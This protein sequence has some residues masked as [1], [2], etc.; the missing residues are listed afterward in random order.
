MMGDENLPHDFE[1]YLS[2][3]LDKE[4]EEAQDSLTELFSSGMA[5]K[6][7]DTEPGPKNLVLAYTTAGIGDFV[8]DIGGI[9][10]IFD[11]QGGQAIAQW[12]KR[13]A[14][15]AILGTQPDIPEGDERFFS[16]DYYMTGI[17]R[18][19][20]RSSLMVAPFIFAGGAGAAALH[21]GAK[22][23][24]IEAAKAGSVLG[25]GLGSGLLAMGATYNEVL[26]E[27]GDHDDAFGKSLK[28]MVASGVIN[29]GTTAMLPKILGDPGEAKKFLHNMFTKSAAVF[30]QAGGEGVDEMGQ[31]VIKGKPA[32][33]NVVD[34]MVLGLGSEVSNVAAFSAA[35]NLAAGKFWKRELDAV[36]PEL[37]NTVLDHVI[38][39]EA[40]DAA[41]PGK[42]ARFQSVTDGEILASG[43][44]PKGVGARLIDI[45]KTEVE[46]LVAQ[47][48]END[49][50]IISK[51][52]AMTGVME[53]MA[54]AGQKPQELT[55]P[56]MEPTERAVSL[57]SLDTITEELDTLHR[58]QKEGKDV[59][60]NLQVVMEKREQA[61]GAL[62]T[63]NENSVKALELDISQSPKS[64]L[65]TMAQE[66]SIRIAEAQKE[67]DLTSPVDKQKHSIASE[68]L[69]IEKSVG[70]KVLG[71]DAQL[72]VEEARID[73]Q[74]TEAV[75]A[76]LAPKY[77]KAGGVLEIGN[78]K[79]I[80]PPTGDDNA[81]IDQRNADFY[82][83][84]N[85][86]TK[87]Q[88]NNPDR[89]QVDPIPTDEKFD[90]REVL[91]DFTDEMDITL[92]QNLK[93]GRGK[94]GHMVTG[95]LH[96]S[97]RPGDMDAVSHETGHWI[98]AVY[99]ITSK[100]DENHEAELRGL[101]P[102]MDEAAE[103][104]TN[105]QVLEEG[106]SEFVRGVMVNPAE[107]LE[108]APLTADLYAETLPDGAQQKILD[109]GDTLR[110]MASKGG[111]DAIR[112]H[113]VSEKPRSLRDRLFKDIYG[114]DPEK[115]DQKTRDWL[116]FKITNMA[117][118]AEL[119][120]GQAVD[121][122]SKEVLPGEDF[123]LL[124]RSL[125]GV[126]GNMEN[127]LNHGMIDT[128][129]QRV[130][131]GG[132][133]W[134]MEPLHVEGRLSKGLL[135]TGDAYM[136]ALREIDLGNRFLADEIQQVFA[137]EYQQEAQLSQY[138]LGETGRVE[139]DQVTETLNAVTQ[140]AHE[141]DSIGFEQA[142]ESAPQ[143]LQGRLK[144][145]DPD[146]HDL[147]GSTGEI[148]SHG[149]YS[150]AKKALKDVD[151]MGEIVKDKLDEYR[152]R[153]RQLDD[154]VLKF[155]HDS[156]MLSD[157]AFEN[158][159]ETGQHHVWFKRVMQSDLFSPEG[160]A[161]GGE[162]KGLSSVTKPGELKAIKGSTEQ[163]YSPWETVFQASGQAI[164]AG[165]RNQT[166]Q[167]FFKALELSPQELRAMTPEERASTTK[168]LNSIAV[169]LAPGE[170]AKGSDHVITYL[171]KG[172][173]V[174]WVVNPDMA[175]S[176]EIMSNPHIAPKPV[177][178]LNN[179][180]KKSVTLMP[181]FMARQILRDAQTRMFL[182]RNMTDEQYWSS[183]EWNP[184]NQ[185]FDKNLD[186]MQRAGGDFSG[187]HHKTPEHYYGSQRAWLKRQTENPATLYLDPAE[188]GKAIL[189]ML[190][191]W[192]T[193]AER[194]N[195]TKEFQLEK[196]FFKK[197]HEEQMLAEG[198]T[199][200]QVDFHAGMFAM[201]QSRDT[202]EFAQMGQ[203]T[204]AVNEWVPFTAAGVAGQR[205]NVR[206]WR[207]DPQLALKK[208]AMQVVAPTI[209]MFTYYALSGNLDEY[210][211]RPRYQRDMEFNIPI[212]FMPNI[213]LAIPLNYEQSIFKSAVERV[214]ESAM[215]RAGAW[216]GVVES[217]MRALVPVDQGMFTGAFGP[218]ITQWTNY[219]IF[220]EKNV[221][222]P[223]EEGKD[224]S[225]KEHA[226]ERAPVMASALAKGMNEFGFSVDPRKT[227][228][229]FRDRLT[230]VGDMA[231]NLSDLLSEERRGQGAWRFTK[232]I[233]GI[234]RESPGRDSQSVQWVMGFGKKFPSKVRKNKHYKRLRKLMKQ[235]TSGLSQQEIADYNEEI[236]ETAYQ[237]RLDLEE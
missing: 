47:V 127:V 121:L 219:E 210:L 63:D 86:L 84:V 43:E 32:L 174:S 179:M 90:H 128:L 191:E 33:Q 49:D 195:R 149:D 188:G 145:L 53:E 3:P 220:R 199:P 117:H 133:D 162:R 19:M 115:T 171:E 78:K 225:E 37:E 104:K 34:A 131:P 50:A 2:D 202:A 109:F 61:L 81:S 92:V 26:E 173:P 196:D 35:Q 103:G 169:R 51:Q 175:T 193:H 123:R 74:D 197:E 100:M 135:E 110:K 155:Y 69:M 198:S 68:K 72:R 217:V 56:V 66:S 101:L 137:P 166:W 16:P 221:I 200:E 105:Q 183:N 87:G 57:Q 12:G 230:Y 23:A 11:E 185:D 75:A 154:A 71:R 165:R 126:G 208:T 151:G 201:G 234:I 207:E 67:L 136:V 224:I 82:Q 237:A 73:P 184:W 80:L 190:D 108:R 113:I 58:I 96:L 93:K 64:E 143:E 144:N 24:A 176:L 114:I 212:P 236:R 138:E 186:E 111:I 204:Q 233:T 148:V 235:S 168:R 122:R 36:S 172:E 107:T 194:L 178:F 77:L 31:N 28:A 181:P 189:N 41:D 147:S 40:A 222:P 30:S 83:S 52:L 39:S 213:S 164:E 142:L 180:F 97:I 160:E 167:S 59:T 85:N 125:L 21:Q 215:G 10:S 46:S 79:I 161:G 1:K 134:L 60:A 94:F 140:F 116:Y 211:E 120:Y 159:K 65:E 156:S 209:A 70:R 42:L 5:L 152:K 216:D 76:L 150:N 95:D 102:E 157:E 139:L 55:A 141:V 48:F 112:S 45:P 54:T 88:V 22:M 206:A 158:M 227:A 118:I 106:L 153:H 163:I 231:L 130:T 27:T 205:Q 29:A 124:S 228:K 89:I 223:Y 214:I 203:W 6:G 20:M 119:Q 99:D 146:K 18:S 129:N 226:Y 4:S 177:K 9:A 132:R 15:Q 187:Y 98:D 192:G 44:R 13:F 229:Y 232:R 17:P 218:E 62:R 91:L 38:L 14:D 7:S 25:S 170:K 182:S 8:S